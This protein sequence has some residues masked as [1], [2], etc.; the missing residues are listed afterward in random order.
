ML[1][2]FELV[3]RF[4]LRIVFLSL[5][6]RHGFINEAYDNPDGMRLTP[7]ERT[8]HPTNHSQVP[9]QQVPSQEP[10]AYMTGIN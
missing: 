2:R 1:F 6:V 10:V 4:T 7:V 8:A 3:C 5:P 9:I